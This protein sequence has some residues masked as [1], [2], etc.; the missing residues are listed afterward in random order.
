MITYFGNPSG[1]RDDRKQLS[2][3]FA[4]SLHLIT[5]GLKAIKKRLTYSE[6]T[7][8]RCSPPITL[9]QTQKSHISYWQHTRHR[10]TYLREVVHLLNNR[11]STGP[12]L[13][14]QKMLKELPKK[15]LLT[16]LYVL[17]LLPYFN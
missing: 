13:I 6:H 9:F 3:P 8:L 12:D 14:T 10:A 1:L 16:L 7:W 2:L 11:K 17:L 4:N 5:L 15:G